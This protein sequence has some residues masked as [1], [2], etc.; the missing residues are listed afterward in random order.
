[1]VAMGTA[2][3]P[4]DRWLLYTGHT[5]YKNQYNWDREWL[6]LTGAGMDRFHCSGNYFLWVELHRVLYLFLQDNQLGESELMDLAE[7]YSQ[8]FRVDSLGVYDA[9]FKLWQ[10]STS[11]FVPAIKEVRQSLVCTHIHC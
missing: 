3:P 9:L 1:M 7:N 8:R 5:L 2:F 6:P 11:E 4:L 10:H